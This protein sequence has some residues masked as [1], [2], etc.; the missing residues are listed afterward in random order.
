MTK[1]RARASSLP[2]WND[3][4][5][6]GAARAWPSVMKRVGFTLRELPPGIGASVGSSV[7]KAAEYTLTRKM[8]DGELGSD[9]EAI[10]AAMATFEERLKDGV[11]WDAT[12]PAKNTGEK[13]IIRM[14]GM[15][16]SRLAPNINPQAVEEIA[17]AVYRNILVSG[18]KDVFCREPNNLRDLKTGRQQTSNVAQYGAYSMLQRTHGHEVDAI[19]EDYIPRVAIKKPQPVPETTYFDL[20]VCEQQAAETLNDIA[21]SI[22][23]FERRVKSG[24]A[25]PEGAFRANPMSMLCSDRYCPAWG[26]DFCRVHKPKKD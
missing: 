22:A 15:Y 19:A 20:V 2:A 6:R 23:E 26:T 16:R 13:Q 14:A 4:A 11:M 21:N 25:P 18:T 1:I 24:D 9:A 10:D 17:Q 7:H 8:A 12:T 3:C 5:R